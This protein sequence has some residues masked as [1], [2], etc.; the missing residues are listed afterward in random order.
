MQMRRLGGI[1][2][3]LR[4]HRNERTIRKDDTIIVS[5]Y[6]IDSSKYTIFSQKLM[7]WRY[8]ERVKVPYLRRT[9][10]RRYW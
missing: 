10:D 4:R 1:R 3:T 8:G 6:V 5:D 7:T 9:S 2:Y